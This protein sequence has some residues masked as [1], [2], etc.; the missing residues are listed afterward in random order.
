MPSMSC[1]ENQKKNP[2]L[3][4]QKNKNKNKKTNKKIKIVLKG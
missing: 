1:T 3:L 2:A 4:C